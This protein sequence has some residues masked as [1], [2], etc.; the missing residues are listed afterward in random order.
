MK[1]GVYSSR[2]CV[3]RG[4]VLVTYTCWSRVFS[5]LGSLHVDVYMFDKQSRRA[6][7]LS[8]ALDHHR[9]DFCTNTHFTINS[10][11]FIHPWT[12]AHTCKSTVK[13]TS[14]QT[15]HTIK[16]TSK[17]TNK[18]PYTHTNMRFPGGYSFGENE[19]KAGKV[20]EECGYGMVCVDR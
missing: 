1:V 16:Q 9:F 20:C 19:N 3:N 7:I 17:Q 5:C 10:D 13:Q 2:M 14:R 12:H 4:C 8:E 15:D 6:R 11:A 18:Q